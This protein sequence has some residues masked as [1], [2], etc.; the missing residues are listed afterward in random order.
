VVDIAG[1]M[2]RPGDWV[3]VD[4]DGILVSKAALT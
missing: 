3:Y 4:A 2:V 1:V